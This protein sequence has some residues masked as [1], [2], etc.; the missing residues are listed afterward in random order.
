M[1][2]WLWYRDVSADDA[3]AWIYILAREASRPRRDGIGWFF[4]QISSARFVCLRDQG[5]R[6]DSACETKRMPV[7]EWGLFL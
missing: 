5:W 3:A 6:R 2:H 7:L 4:R 1:Q